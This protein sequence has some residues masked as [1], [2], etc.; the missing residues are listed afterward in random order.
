MNL[1]HS[2]QTDE[3]LDSLRAKAEQG[4]R[5][6]QFDLAFAL[7]NEIAAGHD[8]VAPN[9][10]EAV[11]WWREAALRGDARAQ[12]NLAYLYSMGIWWASLKGPPRNSEE[13]Q[14]AIDRRLIAAKNGKAEAIKWLHIA[15]ESGHAG[16]LYVI[17]RMYRERAYELTKDEALAEEGERAR[18][19]SVTWLKSL[20]KQ[21]M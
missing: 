5:T 7:S 20:P 8:Y 12:F 10:V 1:K 3:Y 4:D 2:A 13:A 19:H 17:G 18:A 11:R 21:D 16:A 9:F 14:D 6:A 15:G